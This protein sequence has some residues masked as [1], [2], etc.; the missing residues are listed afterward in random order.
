MK[1]TQKGL[2]AYRSESRRDL[3]VNNEDAEHVSKSGSGADLKPKS[4]SGMKGAA[5]AAG[6]SLQA[7][8]FP[9]HRDGLIKT[10]TAGE[11]EK[12]ASGGGTAQAA[13]LLLLLGKE[14]AGK[15][16][17]RMSEKEIE[18]VT[19]E[20]ARINEL[21]RDEA[22]AIL[23]EFG[24][25]LNLLGGRSGGVDTARDFLSAAF[26]AEKAEQI[27]GRA[28]PDALPPPFDFMN[29]LTLPQVLQI[30]SEESE[31]SISVILSFLK[32]EKVSAY[33]KSLDQTAQVRLVRRMARKRDFDPDI[34]SRMGT[35]LQEKAHA[36]GRSDAVEVN[37]KDRLTEILK[38]M[39]GDAE[40]RILGDLEDVH[41]DLGR[42]IRDQLHTIDCIFRMR[43]RDLENL[44]MEMD[45]DRIAFILRGKEDA[46]KEHILAHMS[47]Q[48]KLIVEETMI[49]SPR[50]ARREV[51]KETREFL[52]LIRRREEEGSYVI[53]GP[54]EEDEFI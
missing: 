34:L 10:G 1:F 31:E 25:R 28:V 6:A 37:G 41:P 33:L 22:L 27:I 45:N 13:R 12:E 18:Q 44:L 46:V 50:V 38:H 29:D 32:P 5:H 9:D 17:R 47:S 42:E 26:G 23:Q 8:S 20:I 48:R 51:E 54:G 7:R 19:S 4:E 11:T 21:G 3:S 53:L 52:N 2:D 15:V 16:L 39:G 36:L 43:D 49:L 30:L 24:A 40:K 14:E 35:V